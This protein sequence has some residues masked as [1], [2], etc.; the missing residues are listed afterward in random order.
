MT[1]ADYVNFYRRNYWTG[2]V[3]FGQLLEGCVFLYDNK[4]SQ[5]DMKSD[6]ILLQFDDGDSE[7]PHLV[8]SDFGCALATGS[9]KVPY[10]LVFFKNQR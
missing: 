4:I 9:W 2:R 7:A 8:I 1:L 10:Q 6:N 5:R 3:L